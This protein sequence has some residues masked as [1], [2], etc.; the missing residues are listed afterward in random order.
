M[1][2]QLIFHRRTEI[3]LASLSRRHGI[4]LNGM[5]HQPGEAAAVSLHRREFSVSYAIKGSSQNLVA[6]VR[7][8]Q[9]SEEMGSFRQL[10]TYTLVCGACGEKNRILTNERT[11]TRHVICVRQRVRVTVRFRPDSATPPHMGSCRSHSGPRRGYNCRP[12]S[13]PPRRQRAHP[14][15]ST[16]KMA[17]L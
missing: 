12:W 6:G 13:T 8:D 1:P 4:E 17:R 14:N 5:E 11:K 7:L 9:N 10:V 3:R 2:Y 16:G 15:R